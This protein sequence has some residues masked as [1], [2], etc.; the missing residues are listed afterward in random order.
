MIPSEN[1]KTGTE[2]RKE[3]LQGFSSLHDPLE[4]RQKVSNIMM[5]LKV[6][7]HNELRPEG[8]PYRS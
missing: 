6:S 8:L 7:W 1:R 3:V 5:L 2:N 4:P